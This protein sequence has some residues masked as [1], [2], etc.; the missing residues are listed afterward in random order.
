M[1]LAYRYG[2]ISDRGDAIILR[3]EVHL[4]MFTTNPVLLTTLMAQVGSGE[5]QLPDFQRSWV[6]DDD[7]IRRLLVS[8]LRQ[9]PIG[10]ILLLTEG[11]QLR[12]SK[13]PIEGVIC[14]EDALPDEYLLDGQQRLTSLY[15]A[16][17]FEGAVGTR[18]RSRVVKRFYFVDIR[19]ALAGDYT[20]MVRSVDE[21]KKMP[22]STDR[23]VLLDLSQF[24]TQY[25]HQLMPTESLLGVGYM[26]WMNRYNMHWVGNSE[27]IKE[28][29]QFGEDFLIPL[30]TYQLP[31]ITLK[32]SV[33]RE[34]VCAVFEEVNTAGVTLNV[35]ELLTAM[36]AADDFGLREDWERRELEMQ[37]HDVLKH[38]SAV[39]FLQGV[40]LMA[41]FERARK[42]SRGDA[43]E[44]VGCDRRDILELTKD[45]YDSWA[46]RVQGG[47]IQAA[48]FLGQLRIFSHRDVP[49]AAQL[50]SL[51]AIFTHM[52][53]DL[54][55]KGPLDLLR[56][57]YWCGV[58]G[59]DYG[60][61]TE[62]RL[63]QDLL[64]VPGYLRTGA[65][66]EMLELARFEPQRLISLRSRN[67]AA[68]KGVHALQLSNGCVDWSSGTD[69]DFATYIG[70][71]IN[72]HHIFPR[73]WC[74]NH[75]TEHLGTEIPAW[76]YNSAINKAPISGE[77]NQAIG[78]S[79]PSDYLVRL[80]QA[81]P[82]VD[83][84]LDLSCI[85]PEYLETN[86]FIGFFVAR[87]VA[88][89]KMIYGAM[90]K[91][92]PECEETFREVLRRVNLVRE[93]DEY[94]DSIPDEPDIV[95]TID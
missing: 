90:G 28:G 58:F 30:N 84:H 45:E 83:A 33:P 24:E 55:A 1:G 94:D 35:F 18:V 15:Q 70:K 22:A 44:G 5:L 25:E 56:N 29:S 73:A 68:Y 31:V 75:S 60:S 10:A 57:W 8:V 51:A 69:I 17:K 54:R 47:F 23:G 13:R 93:T 89:T 21:S 12:F 2:N 6:W 19:A 71:N 67:S 27:R 14:D 72:I 74:E 34:A 3:K 62:T 85:K 16:L 38:V 79:A 53:K 65:T 86:D 46:N 88:L 95:P 81:N 7:R 87:G 20:N 41:T 11:D 92:A 43:P 52:G 26:D 32:N 4:G 63:V 48:E 82:D 78:A 91:P 39:R 80:R 9:F 36:F 64:Q 40:C 37:R 49:Y 66:P 59:E 42:G 77:T 50:V 61:S 76:V